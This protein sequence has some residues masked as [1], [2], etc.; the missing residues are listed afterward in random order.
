MKAYNDGGKQAMPAIKDLQTA[1]GRLGPI[2][3]GIDGK[4]IQGTYNA[5]ALSKKL[6][7]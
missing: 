2:P 3:N 4:Y 1:L 7:D 5:V 6:T